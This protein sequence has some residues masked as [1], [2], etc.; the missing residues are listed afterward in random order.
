M[1]NTTCNSLLAKNNIP[2]NERY[3][4]TYLKDK[5]DGKLKV[6]ISK[7]RPPSYK[8]FVKAWRFIARDFK[9]RPSLSL[10]PLTDTL[11]SKFISKVLV[12]YFIKIHASEIIEIYQR[13][14]KIV[15]K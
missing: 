5:F 2:R 8:L 1:M 7:E 6:E 14:Y 4:S 13:S 15:W 3:K 12:T 10:L 11:K 9:G